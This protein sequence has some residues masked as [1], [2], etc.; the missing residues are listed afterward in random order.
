LVRFEEGVASVA[1]TT[2]GLLNSLF[3]KAVP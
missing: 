1:P 2:P 3:P